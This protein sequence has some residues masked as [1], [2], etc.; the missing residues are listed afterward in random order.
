MSMRRHN[1][2]L[3][4]STSRRIMLSMLLTIIVS[5]TRCLFAHSNSR[6]Q[7]CR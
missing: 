3:A 7:M 1:E 5:N 2:I 4:A 6:A